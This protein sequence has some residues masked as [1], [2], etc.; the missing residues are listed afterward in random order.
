MS[1]PKTS[2]YRITAAR[3]KEQERLLAEQRRKR[4]EL[5]ARVAAAESTHIQLEKRAARLSMIVEELRQRFP[6]EKVDV[7]IP[8]CRA[9][10]TEDP[11]RLEEFVG[12][13]ETS[14]LQAETAWQIAGE[15]VKANQDF[16]SAT[17][18]AANLSRG[19]AS[20][21]EAAMRQFIEAKASKSQA[22][23]MIARQTEID[24]IFGRRGGNKWRDAT[25]RLERLVMEA[26]SVE[27]EDRFF[28]LTTE[29]RLQLHAMNSLEER[30]KADAA[31]AKVLLDRLELQIPFGEESLKQRLELVRVGA[32]PFSES[33]NDMA[34]SALARA[35]EAEKAKLQQ[36]ATDIVRGTLTDLGYEVAP[37]EETLFARGG[38]VYFRKSGWNDYCVRLMV[39]PEEGTMNFNVVRVANGTSE[40]SSREADIEAENAWC[41]GYKQLTDTLAAR[42]LDTQL[43]R[44]LPAG[45]VPVQTVGSGEVSM[46]AFSVRKKKGKPAMHAKTLGSDDK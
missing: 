40:Q 36:A 24:R 23:S 32:I 31:K 17:R 37:I 33:F 34:S 44:H 4:K 3:R 7:A 35:H 20:T 18:S 46:S 45:A 11:A 22:N 29:I 10:K 41:S 14:L 8:D 21:V 12:K 27:S 39:R 9:P 38:K 15:Q 16:L 5:A 42:G 6:S 25:P 19:T 28:A 30:R 13:L 26:L 1:G 2:R 43:T